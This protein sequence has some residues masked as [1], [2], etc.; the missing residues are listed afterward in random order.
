[1]QLDLDTLPLALARA[2]R[3]ALTAAQ[4][5]RWEDA[6]EAWGEACELAL[7]ERR[8]D[9][10]RLAA[11]QAVDAFRRDDRPAATLIGVERALQLSEDPVQRAGLSAY[12][13]ACLL[14]AGQL[15]LAEQTARERLAAGVPPNIHAIL[16]DSLAGA[17]LARGDLIGLQAVVHQLRSGAEGLLAEAARFREAQLARLLGHLG[18]AERG[19]HDVSEALNDQPAARGACAAAVGELAELAWVSGEAAEALTLYDEAARL[20]TE[21]GRRG[22]LFSV[23]AGRALAALAAGARPLPSALDEPIAYAES[24]GM[25]LLESRGR[26]ARALARHAAGLP[27]ALDDLNLALRL[28]D[29]AQAP[30][31]AGMSRVL[32]AEAGLLGG[33]EALQRALEDCSGNTPWYARAA[34]LLAE[35]L[36]EQDPVEAGK[37]AAI[38]LSRFT[39]MEIEAGAERAK[40]LLSRV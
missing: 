38:A 19:F 1:M 3:R 14:D 12:L 32:A 35:R 36:L 29:E 15:Q 18:E 31:L 6:G 37:L 27:G 30:W 2:I 23:S 17:L 7:T 11:L 5:A 20:W 4:A 40:A 39:V 13:I 28:A 9:I 10:A 33:V 22:G 16:L 24:R 26:L 8:L 25:P 34:L 21:A